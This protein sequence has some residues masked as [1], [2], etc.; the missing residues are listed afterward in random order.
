ML[1]KAKAWSERRRHLSNPVL[2][3]IKYFAIVFKE[4]C[5][6]VFSAVAPRSPT[7]SSHDDLL[8]LVLSVASNELVLD[9]RR[10]TSN[11]IFIARVKVLGGRGRNAD[12]FYVI[13]EKP[14]RFIVLVMQIGHELWRLILTTAHLGF[15]G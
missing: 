1:M 10:D 2:C 6:L 7:P 12:R 14:R 4:T 3:K 11:R 8:D 15:R 5:L 9:P 13:T